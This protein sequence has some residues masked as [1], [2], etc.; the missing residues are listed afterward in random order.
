M[1]LIRVRFL[2]EGVASDGEIAQSGEEAGLRSVAK[3]EVEN[4]LSQPQIYLKPEG[5]L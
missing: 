3:Q 2:A 1:S 5:G 4:L